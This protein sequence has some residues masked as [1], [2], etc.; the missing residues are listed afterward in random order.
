MPPSTATAL[1]PMR[2]L[3]L[4]LALLLAA[5]GVAHASIQKDPLVKKAVQRIGEVETAESSLPAG[6]AAAADALLKRLAWADKRLGAVV[7]QG[8]AEWKAAKARHDA[9]KTKIETKKASPA[10]RTPPKGTPPGK[11]PPKGKTPPPPAPG[12]TPA[13]DHQKLVLLNQD[14]TREFNNTK[15]L[16]LE[17]FLDGNRVRG[18][19]KAIAKFKQRLAAFPAADAN[20][21]VVAGNVESLESMVQGCLDRIAAD[22]E[23]APAVT[24]RLDTLFDRYGKKDFPATLEPPFREGQIRAWAR[25]LQRRRDVFLP[26][27]LAWLETVRGNVVVGTNRVNSAISN[28][29]VSV[30]RQLRE[31]EDYV[32]QG[33]DGRARDGAEFA[34]WILETDPKDRNQV[35]SR[36]LGK[37]RFDENMTRLR[38]ASHF[39]DM[40]RIL[41]EELKRTG[42]PDR[43]AQDKG[44][45]RGIEQL[46][47][48]ARL[49]LSEV[50]MPKAASEDPKLLEI[51]AETLKRKDYEVGE[52]KR[53]VINA[54]LVEKSKREAWLDPGTVRSTI[55][56]Y[57]YVWE[58]FQVTTVEEV[59][60]ELWLFANTLKRYS[61]GDSTTPVGRWILSRRFELTPILAENV[62][63]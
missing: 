21:K 28:L 39:V 53:L 62:G 16:R 56:L 43:D 12:G 20:V 50:R 10:P 55:T 61:S 11:T 42:A 13:Y 60:G 36:V 52:W 31:S 8:T 33:M 15:I 4:L 41:D 6:D 44:I 30:K 34:K 14:V 5:P 35:L 26:E 58:Q 57:D 37:G 47:E 18:L 29:T 3:L 2:L 25:E 51:A 32:V 22:R 27:D 19:Q 7:Q 59:D 23:A 40:A 49:T 46:K 17:N 38:E 45:A 54:P 63:N 48:L 24:A 9:V 1:P